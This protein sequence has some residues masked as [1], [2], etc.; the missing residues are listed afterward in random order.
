LSCARSIGSVSHG[1]SRAKPAN[2][3][4]EYRNPKQA[5]DPKLK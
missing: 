2:E 5:Q 4:S 1:R 3:K